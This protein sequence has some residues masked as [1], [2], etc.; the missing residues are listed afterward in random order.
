MEKLTKPK[1]IN[2][3]CT[4]C[5]T[6][7]VLLDTLNNSE[8]E[9]VFIDEWA[10]PKCYDGSTIY[11]DWSQEYIDEIN[12]RAE[13]ATNHPENMIPWEDVRYSMYKKLG[14]TDE[15]I[16]Q[17]IKETEEE[18]KNMTD[19]DWEEFDKSIKVI[20]NVKID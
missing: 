18:V 6:T 11:M 8:S 19:E 15:E 10:C 16:E 17:K 13:E 1:Y 4:E 5:S 20:R 14:L 12:R 3:N 9:Y 7:L 2:P